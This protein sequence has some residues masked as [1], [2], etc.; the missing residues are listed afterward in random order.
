MN[1]RSNA[2]TSNYLDETS[3]KGVH[4]NDDGY[5]H[6]RQIVKFLEYEVLSDGSM[7]L[8][9]DSFENSKYKRSNYQYSLRSSYKNLR[10]KVRKDFYRTFL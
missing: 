10:D 1:R 4:D 6:D 8:R 7:S 3:N 2:I 5:R 9:S